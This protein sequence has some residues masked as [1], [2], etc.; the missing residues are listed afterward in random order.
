MS[1][2]KIISHSPGFL[3]VATIT[4]VTDDSKLG[5]IILLAEPSPKFLLHST[6]L[7]SCMIQRPPNLINNYKEFSGST[8]CSSACGLL[9]FYRVSQ[10]IMWKWSSSCT[11]I[12]LVLNSYLVYWTGNSLST[13]GIIWAQHFCSNIQVFQ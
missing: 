3:H 10:Y 5:T 8:K 2:L 9:L 13:T 12:Y 11:D 7:S 1:Y 6:T 4:P